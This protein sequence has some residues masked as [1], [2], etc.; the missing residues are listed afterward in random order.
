M[1]VLSANA[2]QLKQLFLNLIQNAIDAA[3]ESPNGVVSVRCC[4]DT[5]TVE[6]EVNDNGRGIPSEIAEHL[7]EP[8]QTTKRNGMGLGLPLSRQIVE[9][10]GGQLWWERVRPQGTCFHF[11]LPIDCHVQ[12]H[13]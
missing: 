10:H 11:R 4:H 3:C 12:H 7:F 5:E 6:V 13:F 1:P 2:R 8:F 9:S